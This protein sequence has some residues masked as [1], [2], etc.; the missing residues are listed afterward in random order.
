MAKFK[1]M[2]RSDDMMNDFAKRN[3]IFLSNS[4]FMLYI[5]GYVISGIGTRL[6]TIAISSKILYIR[7][8]WCFNRH[9]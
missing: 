7:N 8:R 5:I 2:E 9:I 3:K 1:I 6:T 4:N